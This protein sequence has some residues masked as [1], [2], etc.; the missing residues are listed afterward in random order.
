MKL[1]VS[2]ISRLTGISV[3]TL[4]Y[5]DEINLLKPSSVDKNN[6]YRYY[7][8]RSLERLQ[9]I[10]FYRELDFSLKTILQII[11]S[12]GYNKKEALSQQ[13]HLLTLKKKR[14]ERLIEALDNELEGEY[15][16]K[17]DEFKNSEYEEAREKY[18]QEASRKWGDTDAYKES[19]KKTGLYS[20]EKWEQVN[21]E[22]DNIMREFAECMKK[23][24]SPSDNQAQ[25]LVEKWRNF[26]SANYYECTKEILAGL[27]QMY[28]ADERFREN[29]DKHSDGTAEFI[30]EAIKV[31]CR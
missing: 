2:E 13:K 16:M 8:E 21:K 4:H 10:L 30:S 28:I 27:G 29:I 23:G 24:A 25:L 26:I 7:D 17:F 5:Y 12:P 14:L 1:S 9:E 15:T 20:D 31:Y 3:R 18:A 19:Q 6:G 11:T 22:T